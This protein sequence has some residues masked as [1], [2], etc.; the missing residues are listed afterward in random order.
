MSARLSDW[1]LDQ[2]RQV[3]A[4]DEGTE[5]TDQLPVLRSY[6][7]MQRVLEAIVQSADLERAA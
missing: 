5:V 7:N 1:L 4:D 3:L 6:L 2:A